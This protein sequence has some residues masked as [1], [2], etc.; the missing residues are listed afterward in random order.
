MFH[1]NS[2]AAFV[3]QQ[4]KKWS[5]KASVGFWKVMKYAVP[6]WIL[7]YA[8]HIPM[9]YLIGDLAQEYH[10]SIWGLILIVRP[11]ISMIGLIELMGIMLMALCAVFGLGS[12]P[13]LFVALFKPHLLYEEWIR[14]QEA[15]LVRRTE[16]DQES[17]LPDEHESNCIVGLYDHL[18]PLTSSRRW[19]MMFLAITVQ[20]YATACVWVLFSIY[21]GYYMITDPTAQDAYLL[22]F[23]ASFFWQTFAVLLILLLYLTMESECVKDWKKHRDSRASALTKD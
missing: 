1:P 22:Q 5:W 12:F 4:I 8:L 18:F 21:I 11:L 23:I 6:I 13:L 19:C 20:F 9:Q 17:L 16:V 14:T 7:L 10:G 3:V 15:E 2:D